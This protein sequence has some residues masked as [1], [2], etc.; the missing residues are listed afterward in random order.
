MK[1]NAEKISIILANQC[2]SATDLR[3]TGMAPTTISKIMR[4]G[5]IRCKTA[6]RLAAAL[7]VPVEEL[8]E[9]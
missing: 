4:G 2:K 9:G 1:L 8:L 3:A 6:G 7:G 5:E